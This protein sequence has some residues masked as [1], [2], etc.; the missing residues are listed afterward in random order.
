M[1]H[2]KQGR[3]GSQLGE[4]TRGHADALGVSDR[5]KASLF[6]ALVDVI[7]SRVAAKLEAVIEQK[8]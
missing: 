6:D 5:T 4:A 1:Q 8:V 2:P 7:A 3:E